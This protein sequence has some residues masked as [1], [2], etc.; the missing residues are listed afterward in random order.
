[1]CDSKTIDYIL[2]FI[3]GDLSPAEMPNFADW[4]RAKP[5]HQLCYAQIMEIRGALP[6]DSSS[7]FDEDDAWTKLLKRIQS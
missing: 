7:S 1:M 5:E 2:R 3:G 4:L 6:P